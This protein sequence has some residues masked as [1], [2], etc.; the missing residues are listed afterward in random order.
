MGGVKLVLLQRRQ[1]THDNF[2][3]KNEYKQMTTIS[4]KRTCKLEKVS[5]SCRACNYWQA[6]YAQISTLCRPPTIGLLSVLTH[7]LT[8]TKYP[9][10]W[11]DS[12]D[13]SSNHLGTSQ[14]GWEDLGWE[15]VFY[16]H[17][18]KYSPE[19]EM[20]S[21]SRLYR[22]TI[23]IRNSNPESGFRKSHVLQ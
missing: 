16:C 21:V 7:P 9:W 15:D 4:K 14:P 18:I 17:C 22:N 5:R 2:E 6:I 19:H 13:T 8:H 11:Q 23:A 10:V 12:Q 1:R 20:N 3:H